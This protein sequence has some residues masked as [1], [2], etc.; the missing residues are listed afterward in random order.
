M[1]SYLNNIGIH[2]SMIFLHS[3]TFSHIHWISHQFW[4]CRFVLK[5][6]R[7]HTRGA[8]KAPLNGDSPLQFFQVELGPT[9]RSCWFDTKLRISLLRLWKKAWSSFINT[10]ILWADSEKV[11]YFIF[12]IFPRIKN[13]RPSQTDTCPLVLKMYLLILGSSFLILLPPM[14]G[15]FQTFHLGHF[16]GTIVS[17]GFLQFCRNPYKIDTE[18]VNNVL[19]HHRGSAPV[20]SIAM[21]VAIVDIH[22]LRVMVDTGVYLPPEIQHQPNGGNLLLSMKMAGIAPES[23]DAVVLTHCHLDHSA[24]LVSPEDRP[25]FP[26]AKI[27]IP[28]LDHDFWSNP[29]NK[30]ERHDYDELRTYH[31]EENYDPHRPY[32]LPFADTFHS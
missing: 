12:T 2:R 30:T 27:Y 8:T 23:I 3:Y 16:N 31:T 21:N 26:N 6:F 9:T 28:R 18:I 11:F 19:R 13:S 20:H 10:I 15:I 1:I 22:G 24:G 5:S 29:T 14:H 4:F 7:F 25:A 32:C 17:D